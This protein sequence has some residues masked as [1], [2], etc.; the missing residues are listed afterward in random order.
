MFLN[1]A[2]ERKFEYK[3]LNRDQDKTFDTD[4][5]YVVQ[6]LTEAKGGKKKHE[7]LRNIYVR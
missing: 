5:F 4:V 6:I 3:Q 1:C 7:T 2:T